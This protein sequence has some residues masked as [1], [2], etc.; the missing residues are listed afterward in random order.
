MRLIWWLRAA[1]CAA[2]A[3]VAGPRP[4]FLLASSTAV[5]QALGLRICL[6][7]SDDQSFAS[8]GHHQLHGSSLMVWLVKHHCLSAHLHAFSTVVPTRERC[9]ADLEGVQHVARP[10]QMEDRVIH[11]SVLR[12][13]D[14][15]QERWLRR[16]PLVWGLSRLWS[17]PMLLECQEQ[18]VSPEPSESVLFKT[19]IP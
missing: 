18:S 5:L 17:D 4:S 9:S 13:S 14:C 7:C 1:A 15:V 10:L 2:M 19:V 8:A 11:W 3:L 12:R 16:W 6:D